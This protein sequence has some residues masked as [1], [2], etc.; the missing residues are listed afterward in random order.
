MHLAELIASV[1]IS[2]TV[3]STFGVTQWPSSK[4]FL[5]GHGGLERCELQDEVKGPHE[6]LP[7]CQNPQ[8]GGRSRRI[9][10]FCDTRSG[11]LEPTTESKR[12]CQPNR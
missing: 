9:R 2:V 6:A 8:Y 4:G 1:S 7:A 5:A 12:R 3:V 11:S 10:R